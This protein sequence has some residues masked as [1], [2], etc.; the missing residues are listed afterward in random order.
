MFGCLQ[1]FRLGNYT[2]LVLS[3]MWLKRCGDKLKSQRSVSYAQGWGK[4]SSLTKAR[5]GAILLQSHAQE[6]TSIP[7]A[8]SVWLDFSDNCFSMLSLLFQIP[9]RKSNGCVRLAQY[10]YCLGTKPAAYVEPLPITL[11][12]RILVMCRFLYR[13]RVTMGVPDGRRNDRPD[14]ASYLACDFLRTGN[15]ELLDSIYGPIP[16]HQPATMYD[17]NASDTIF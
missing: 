10:T 17:T 7:T 3:K 12:V 1:G 13:S 16:H 6:M 4:C 9:T 15:H 11:L 2:K 5:R 14:Y 8:V